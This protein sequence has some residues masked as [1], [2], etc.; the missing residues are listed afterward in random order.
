[1]QLT[2]EHVE[3]LALA[4][5]GEAEWRQ[6]LEIVDRYGIESY[7]H[8]INRVKVAILETSEGKL[9]R[10]PYFVECA[11]IDYRDVLTGQR[12]PPMSEAQEAEWQATANAW[13]ERWKAK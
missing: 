9:S 3:S 7:E 8:E 4:L 13:L 12:L 1:M 5:F 6:A 2:R 10:L 11:K